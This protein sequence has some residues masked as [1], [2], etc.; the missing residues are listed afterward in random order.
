MPVKYFAPKVTVSLIFPP[1]DN[2]SQNNEQSECFEIGIG[3]FCMQH[4]G[5]KAE[6]GWLGKRLVCLEWRDIS[7]HRHVKEKEKEKGNQNEAEL[8]SWMTLTLF[9]IN[10]TV[11]E[12]IL[13]VVYVAFSEEISF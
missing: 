4:Y 13:F 10:H 11:K 12:M 9:A 1:R 3:C 8:K 5:E 6:T 7:T 2:C